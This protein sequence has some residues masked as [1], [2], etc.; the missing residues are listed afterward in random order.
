M[1]ETLTGEGAPTEETVGFIGQRYVDIAAV[2][3]YICV[4]IS[5]TD[6]EKRYVWQAGGTMTNVGEP[7]KILW[8]ERGAPTLY[9]KGETGM[10]AFDKHFGLMYA[11][12]GNYPA[13]DTD[14]GLHHIWT[15]APG[16]SIYNYPP[17][18]DSEGE[19]GQLWADYSACELYMC[20]GRDIDL[21]DKKMIYLWGKVFGAGGSLTED[22]YEAIAAKVPGH[23]KTDILTLTYEDGTAESVQVYVV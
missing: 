14:D 23:M 20:I 19:W 7:P 16:Y 15:L 4:G 8:L 18:E 13:D 10:Y 3:E 12:Y 9:T 21:E 17:T 2:K 6:G 1:K 11:Y 22:D 5:V